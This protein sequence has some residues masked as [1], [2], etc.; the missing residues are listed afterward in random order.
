LTGGLLLPEETKYHKLSLS[1]LRKNTILL[2]VE[3]RKL[4]KVFAR[5]L[6]GLEMTQR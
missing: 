2:V 6:L 1:F 3:I 5:M 4:P